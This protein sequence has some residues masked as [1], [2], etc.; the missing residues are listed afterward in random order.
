MVVTT[1][2]CGGQQMSA[3]GVSRQ[4]ETKA[5]VRRILMT[6]EFAKVAVRRYTRS[7]KRMDSLVMELQRECLGP[8][9]SVADLLRKALVVARELG[10]RDLQSW[11]ENELNGYDATIKVPPYRITS[12][13][14][15]NAVSRPRLVGAPVPGFPVA[16]RNCFTHPGGRESCGTGGTNCSTGGSHPGVG[17]FEPRR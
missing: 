8:G 17:V 6:H 1:V 5:P 11:I 4:V 14:Y 16:P 10:V 15:R 12:E 7:F 13:R 9:V 2:A 3:T